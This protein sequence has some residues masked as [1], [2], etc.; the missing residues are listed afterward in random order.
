MLNSDL[1]IPVGY[2]TSKYGYAPSR[3]A[4]LMDGPLIARIRGR[5]RRYMSWGGNP[6]DVSQEGSD[7]VGDCRLLVLEIQIEECKLANCSIRFLMVFLNNQIELGE[8]FNDVYITPAHTLKVFS[9]MSRKGVKFSG[10]VTPLFDSM[11]VPYQAPEGEGSEQPTEP[12]PTPSPTQ[13]ST[14]DQPPVTD[15]SSS[16]DTTQDSRDSLE[17]T[18]RSEG[19]QVLALEASK[20][21]QAV[22]IT[23]LKA[24]INK[25]EKKRVTCFGAA[26]AQIAGAIGAQGLAKILI[27]VGFSSS[28]AFF[29]ASAL[30]AF[31]TTG[32]IE[33]NMMAPPNDE[34]VPSHSGSGGPSHSPSWKEDSFEINVLLEESET[35]GTSARSSGAARDEAGP[36]RQ[37]YIN[38]SFEASMRNRILRLE[39]DDSPY[40]LGKAKGTYWSDIRLMLEHAPSQNEYNRLLEFENKDLQI[41]ELQHECFRLFEGF[42]KQNPPLSDQVPYNPQEAFKD[43]LNEDYEKRDQR[44]PFFIFDRDEKELDFLS[45]VRQRLKKEGPAYV[46]EILGI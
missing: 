4:D 29:L 41:R 13:P 39:Q 22:E 31:F 45:N 3:P 21:A 1:L 19:D 16:H 12:Q 5:S 36:P 6:I 43:F 32:V 25:L 10:K 37:D 23:K 30:R 34:I 14:G 28:L 15:S 9:N 42:L 26:L 27:K 11:L 38:R 2:E 17:G 7:E 35:E 18:N 44:F 40:L 8:P 20:D 24:R 33:G 46:R